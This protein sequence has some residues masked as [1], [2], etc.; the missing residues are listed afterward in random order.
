MKI[1]TAGASFSTKK[2]A[3]NLVNSLTISL[4]VSQ[5]FPLSGG[6]GGGADPP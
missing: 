4:F 1:S 6:G 3:I 5:F 2:W